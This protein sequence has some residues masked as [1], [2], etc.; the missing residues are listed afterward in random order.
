MNT[1][2]VQTDPMPEK[3]ESDE[4]QVDPNAGGSAGD[5]LVPV[6]EAKKYRKRA[7]AAEQS[8]SELQSALNEK[9]QRVQELEQTV[10]ELERQR[11]VDALLTEAEAI[12]L[13]AARLLTEVAVRE[14]DEPDI[15][16]AVAELK[17]RK[18]YLF[19]QRSSAS[20]VM[21]ANGQPRDRRAEH[22]EHAAAEAAATGK[23]TD[24]LR[25][26]RL[27]RS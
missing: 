8:L 2:H 16:T 18:P 13:D 6:T 20:R 10:T 23:R 22:V 24:L 25:Y 9:A 17:Q 3:P 11:Q 27:R 26:L 7:Q 12:D 21:S 5:K 14:M 4:T 15:E 19:R 1:D